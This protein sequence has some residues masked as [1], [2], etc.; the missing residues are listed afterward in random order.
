MKKR[1]TIGLFAQEVL[2]ERMEFVAVIVILVCTMAV[3]VLNIKTKTSLILDDG[4]INY[5][6]YV[7]NHR[8]NG[9][10]TLV[11]E[12]GDRYEGNFVNG[13]FSGHGKFTAKSG[14]TYEG[15]FQDGQADG[16]G[17]LT[18][19]NNAVYKGKFKQGIYRK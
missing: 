11:Y 17:T 4:K 5:T 16:Q 7:L 3:F 13:T 6:G 19:E 10:G 2:R 8:M 18:T 1:K 14:W 9:Q 12:N 15:D